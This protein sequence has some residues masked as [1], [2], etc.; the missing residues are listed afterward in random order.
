MNISYLGQKL[1]GAAASDEG[2][3]WDG[4]S[5]REVHLL[6]GRTLQLLEKGS[7]FV[8]RARH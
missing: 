1:Q 7:V 4:A 5:L 2:D 6:L 8:Y 3:G